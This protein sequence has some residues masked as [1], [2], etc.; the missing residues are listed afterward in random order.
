MRRIEAVT[1]LAEGERV[2]LALEAQGGRIVSAR[3]KSTR[4]P[5]VTERMTGR[6]LLPT[7][8]LVPTLFPLCARA[9]ALAA[10]AA[11]EQ[12]AAIRPSDAHLHARE[13]LLVAERLESHLRALSVEIPPRLGGRPDLEGWVQVRSACHRLERALFPDGTGFE[14][15]G[16]VLAPNLGELHAAREE[17]RDAALRELEPMEPVSSWMKR[18]RGN[19]AAAA[20][21]LTSKGW[22]ELGAAEQLG[23]PAPSEVARRARLAPGFVE[24]PTD[25]GGP[26]E[27]GPLARQRGHPRVL[28]VEARWGLGWLARVV[29]RLADLSEDL[30]MLEEGIGQ[31]QPASGQTVVLPSEGEGYG[32]AE[33]ARGILVHRIAWQDGRIAAWQRVAPTEWTHHPEGVATRACVG[34]PVDEARARGEAHLALLDPCVPFSVVVEG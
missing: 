15:G 11:V 9:Q 19:G 10:L 32:H 16:G 22:A 26:V 5:R 14:L 6:L 7:L 12:G 23:A 13:L 8:R 27:L 31:L 30:R 34:W 20:R 21:W 3:S 17:I 24:A 18:S 4:R 29:A 33:T 1:E 28:E 2:E 25:E